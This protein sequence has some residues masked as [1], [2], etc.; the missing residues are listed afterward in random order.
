MLSGLDSLTRRPGGVRGLYIAQAIGRRGMKTNLIFK[1]LFFYAIVI[2]LSPTSHASEV[3]YSNPAPVTYSN[4]APYTFSTPVPV[5]IPSTAAIPPSGNSGGATL[6]VMTS[7]EMKMGCEIAADARLSVDAARGS[8]DAGNSIKAGATPPAD[9]ECQ[10]PTSTT[11]ETQQEISQKNNSP[12]KYSQEGARCTLNG[13]VID[14]DPNGSTDCSGF[15]SGVLMRSGA[16]FVAGQKITKVMTTAEILPALESSS[17][18]TKGAGTPQPGDMCVYNDGTEGHVWFVDR[19]SKNGGACTRIESTGGSDPVNGGISLT[20]ENGVAPSCNSKLSG[21]QK[22][23]CGR[24]TGTPDCT[25]PDAKS[26]IYK[27][28][29]KVSNCDV[30]AKAK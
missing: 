19:V 7:P 9:D 29:S 13:N 12:M 15:A 2:V 30:G 8:C 20:A 28:E 18:W 5:G 22:V 10:A 21:S 4:P 1:I 24:P 25:D 23:V 6:P 26:R 27:N 3:K 11:G 14:N 17:C 16:E